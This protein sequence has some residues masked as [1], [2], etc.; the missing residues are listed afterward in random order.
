MGFED[1]DAIA[2]S[3]ASGQFDADVAEPFRAR[4][5]ERAKSL[6]TRGQG[7]V[8]QQDGQPLAHFHPAIDTG[9]AQ[10]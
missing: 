9:P 8:R 1:E 4:Q 10:E 7:T 6:L 5:L 3:N 2:G